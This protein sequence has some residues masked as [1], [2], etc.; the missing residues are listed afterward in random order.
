MTPSPTPCK[1]FGKAQADRYNAVMGDP[2]VHIELSPDAKH[3]LVTESSFRDKD[4]L[5]MVPGV[6]FDATVNKW[7]AEASFPTCHAFRGVFGDRLVIEPRLWDWASKMAKW[8]ADV[9]AFTKALDAEGNLDEYPFQRAGT[10]WLKAV[11][12]GLLADEM[13][14]GKTVQ[15][16][17]ALEELANTD[18]V[19]FAGD[20]DGPTV[21]SGLDGPVLIVCPNS[22][23]RVW[24]AHLAKWAPSLKAE[25]VGG[26]KNSV[27]ERRKTFARLDS[28]EINVVII[29]W[30]GLR[31]HSRLKGF[32]QISLS[33]AEKEPKELNRHWA[34]VIADEAHRGKDPKSKQTRALWAASED[35]DYRWAFTGTPIANDPSDL[36]SILHYVN[37]VNWPSKSRW[38]DRYALQS[39]NLFGVMDIVGLN[40]LTEPELRKSLDVH[41]LRRSKAEVLPYLPPVVFEE[42]FVNLSPK[43]RKSYDDMALKLVAELDDGSEIVGWNPMTKMTRLLQFASANMIKDPSYVRKNED[44]PEEK[45]IMIDTPKS[46]KLNEMMSVISDTGRKQVVVAA[47]FTPADRVG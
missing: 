25:I 34:V 23:K 7:Y 2:N 37:P 38:V 47:R 41:M 6:K 13:G 28:G 21:L 10:Q 16:C 24:L 22:V 29:N 33:T 31:G 20:V 40:P 27:T 1:I 19:K 14:T 4:L 17:V 32:G 39:W 46:S 9:A 42:R 3:I 5:K 43:E 15:A 18:I 30:E 11:K 8:S 12:Y 26:K 36:W 35:A 45:F 44:D